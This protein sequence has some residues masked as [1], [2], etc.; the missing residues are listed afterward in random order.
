[1][2]KVT[3]LHSVIGLLYVDVAVAAPPRTV[4]LAVKNLTCG[5]C[6]VVVAQGPE[7]STGGDRYGHLRSGQ[8]YFG[9]AHGSDDQRGISLEAISRSVSTIILGS[10]LTC[11][12]C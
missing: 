1:M 2:R 11:P 7:A 10:L 9:K 12:S 4:T 8:G 6:P 5:T 3:P